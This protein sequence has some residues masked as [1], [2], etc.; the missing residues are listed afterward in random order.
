MLI[1]DI[2][3]DIDIGHRGSK[4]PMCGLLQDSRLNMR[5]LTATASH[6]ATG[7]QLNSH[8]SWLNLL[9]TCGGFL[10]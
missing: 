7:T 1:I 2:D 6:F 8:E 4:N 9:Q 3:I 10:K 5:A